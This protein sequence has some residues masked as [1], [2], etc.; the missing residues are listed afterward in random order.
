MLEYKVQKVSQNDIKRATDVLCERGAEGWRVIYITPYSQD[1][2]VVMSRR[3]EEKA[4]ET[5][6]KRKPGRPKKKTTK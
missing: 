5:P 2:I 4:K 6:K 3:K 1:L